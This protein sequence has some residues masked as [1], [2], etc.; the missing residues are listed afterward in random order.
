MVIALG[1]CLHDHLTLGCDAIAV[2]AQGI[3]Q[4]LTV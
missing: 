1:E 4:A 2:M 3:Q